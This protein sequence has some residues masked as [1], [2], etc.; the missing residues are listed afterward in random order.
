MAETIALQSGNC[1]R[2]V[3]SA[4]CEVGGWGE[5]QQPM[6]I[7]GDRKGCSAGKQ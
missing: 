5:Q 4:G 1:R 6:E 2:G 7:W 3:Q